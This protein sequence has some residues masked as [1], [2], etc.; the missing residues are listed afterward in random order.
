M[1][2]PDTHISLSVPEDFPT[3]N[4]PQPAQI[5]FKDLEYSVDIKNS[6]SND[7]KKIKD[8]ISLKKYESKKKV[9]LDQITGSFSPGRLTAILGPSGSGKTSLL[10]LLSGRISSGKVEGNI[11]LNGRK[12]DSGSLGLV[13]RFISQDDVMLS[14]MTVK[15]VIEMAINFRVS[16]ITPEE[17]SIRT[18]EA[19]TT[20]E[21]DKCQN[22]LIGDTITKGI[23]GGERKRTSIAMEMATDSSILFLDEP[24]SGLDMYTS[25][26]V[27][28]LLRYISRSGQTVVSV[29]H[30]PSSDIFKMFDDIVL[31]SE[32]KIVY[33]GPQ[34]ELV[35]YFSKL[36][37]QCPNYTNPAD[38]VFTDVLNLN[39]A[40]IE[41]MKL[42][43]FSGSKSDY[44]VLKINDL[45][46]KW[47]N[48]DQYEVIKERVEGPILDSLNQFN[49]TSSVSA[50]RQ[51]TLLCKRSIKDV[52]RNKLVL[53]ARLIQAIAISLIM[54]IVFYKS[55]TKSASTLIQNFF[56]SLFFGIVGQFIPVAISVLSTFGS[57]KFVFQREY[58]NGYYKTRPYFLAKILIELPV[59]IIC[60]II[61]SAISYFM[62]GYR[63]VFAKFLIHTAAMILLSLTS[64]SIGIFAS[65]FFDDLSV[66]LAILPL[67][68]IIPMIFSGFLVN[69]GDTMSWIGWLQWISPIKYAFTIAATNQLRG[70]TVNGIDLG[71]SSLKS[72]NLGPFSI[73]ACFGF[74]I[75]F[76]VLFTVL[77]Y[78]G[79]ERFSKRSSLQNSRKSTKNTKAVLL[80]PPDNIF[81]K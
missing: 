75:M 68:L 76:F 25:S 11:W 16:G 15:E 26:L 41:Q 33:F 31:L 73:P 40:E 45:A 4:K 78:F 29:I 32:G 17:L 58:Q 67:L 19:I 69:S 24:T 57:G 23:S 2:K 6:I 37:F 60:P 72:L 48:S 44:R 70:Y 81:S 8:I 54:G 55:N 71:D 27:V 12:A 14:T 52:F 50:Y 20:L 36:G 77:G 35:D 49:F 9:I 22:T 66:A 59:Q 21:L 3:S 18:K 5:N 34:E 28:K 53:R 63:G 62:I 79:L 74:L 47:K 42:E 65:T 13:S 10:N 51:F 64:F 1:E 7:S 61:F 43:K 38:F 56:G 46:E 80:G 30:Q 39:E